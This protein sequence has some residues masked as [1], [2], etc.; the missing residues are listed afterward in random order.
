MNVQRLVSS[1]FLNIAGV[2]SKF[3]KEQEC[4]CFCVTQIWYVNFA[5]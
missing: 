3:V 5:L 1:S 4:L 2:V